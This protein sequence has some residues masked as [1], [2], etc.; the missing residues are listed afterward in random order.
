[1]EFERGNFGGVIHTAD[2][3]FTAAGRA[4]YETNF[5][6]ATVETKRRPAPSGTALVGYATCYSK[7]H[8]G[9]DRQVEAFV[10]GAFSAALRSH[11]D[12]AFLKNH[13]WSRCYGS[14]TTGELELFE[15]DAGLAFKL[16]VADDADGRE[17]LAEVDD[18]RLQMSVG[19]TV[20][21]SETKDF[22]GTEVRLIRQAQL[23]EISAV[24]RP[25]VQET[26]ITTMPAGA[27]PSLTD[28]CR[29]GRMK[30]LAAAGHFERRLAALRRAL[31]GIA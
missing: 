17:L 10:A 5:H 2:G 29:S 4:A 28:L 25:A 12:V 6:R 15:D 1:M 11:R 26:S 22:D 3:S 27:V 24:H 18:G 23:G 20:D 14:T 13:S 30:S 31:A 8:Y 9:P 16:L 7:A 21:L 19:Y